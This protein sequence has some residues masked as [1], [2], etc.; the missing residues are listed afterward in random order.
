MRRESQETA[1]KGV[2]GVLRT[3]PSVYGPKEK[4]PLSCWM[5]ERSGHETGP[6]GYT[7]AGGAPLSLAPAWL[8]PSC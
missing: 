6:F 2:W 1:N 4:G 8:G 3:F 5:G 7:Q